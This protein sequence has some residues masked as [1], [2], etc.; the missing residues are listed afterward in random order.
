MSSQQNKMN[1]VLWFLFAIVIPIIIAASLTMIVLSAAGVNVMG[2]M[3]ETGSNIPVVS[4]FVK[5][6]EE[7][8]NEE[9]IEEMSATIA[10]QKDE[11]EQLNQNI[12]DLEY[13]IEQLEQEITVLENR[14]Q[15]DED[16]TEEN[17]EQMNEADDTIKKLSASFRKMNKKQAALI[18]QDLDPEI[19]VSM[20][21][22]LSNDTRGGILESM[23][24]KKAAQ[25]TQLY[26]DSF[27]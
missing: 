5:T 2:W 19:A 21:N 10:S 15:H 8:K 22:E 24:P 1:P 11:I 13:T 9:L 25:L 23:D 26:I 7:I 3:K 18:F 6:D 12:D 17:N 20:L 16:L 4:T 27:E 14:D